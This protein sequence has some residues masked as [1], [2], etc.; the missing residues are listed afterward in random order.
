MEAKEEMSQTETGYPPRQGL[1]DPQNE[2]DACGLGFVVD[3]K[4]RASHAI[5]EQALQVLMH[6]EHRGAAGAEKNAGDGAG[7]LFQAPDA[8]LAAEAAKLGVKRP[9]AGAYAA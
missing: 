5:V 2:K 6:P 8:F 1:Y 9:G 3:I 4:G 7:I